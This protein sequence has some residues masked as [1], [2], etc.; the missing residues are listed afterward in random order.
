[1]CSPAAAQQWLD[2]TRHPYNA[3]CNGSANDTAAIQKAIL[4]ARSGTISPLTNTVY[5][6]A[7]TCMASQLIIYS[8]VTLIGDGSGL[9]ASTLKQIPGTNKDFLIDDPA[10]PDNSYCHGLVVKQ[11]QI[12][13]DTTSI[14]GAG[15]RLSRCRWGEHGKFDDLLLSDFADAAISI[16]SGGT[17]IDIENIHMFRNGRVTE[18][19]GLNL[20]RESGDVWTQVL[21]REIS[22]DGNKPALIRLGKSGYVLNA[23]QVI[24]LGVKSECGPLRNQKW[25]IWFDGTTGAGWLADISGV[26]AWCPLPVLGDSAA[27]RINGPAT[28]RIEWRAVSPFNMQWILSDSA[29]N[30]F[31]PPSISNTH[32][33]T[34]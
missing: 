6:P 28:S 12:R 30:V 25:P 23:E 5:V 7:K 3:V 14:V 31:L 32:G 17:A 29:R 18:R 24:I 20:D 2:V 33:N 11:L 16:E 9:G 34:Y 22:G 26:S 27:I 15:I 8:P 21:L 4:D 1:V 10:L 19:G 13:G